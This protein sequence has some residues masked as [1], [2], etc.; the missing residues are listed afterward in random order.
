M[1]KR[2]FIKTFGAI[3]LIPFSQNIRYDSL[4]KIEHLLNTE[5]LSDD[6]FWK[7]VRSQ[8]DLHQDFINLESGYYNIIPKPTLKKQI[9]HI[10]RVNLEG[11]FYMRKSRFKDKSTITSELANFVGCNGKN[12][13]ITR[14]TTESLDLIISGFPWKSGDEAIYAYQD[15]GAMQDMFEQIGKRHG[16]VLKKVSVP[17]H[18]KNDMELISL[19]ESQITSKTRLIMISHMVNIT[20][21]IL[22]V[23]K[24]CDMAHSYGVE[25]LVDGAHC[26]GHFNFKI[27]N[28]NCDYYGSSLHKWLATPLG[29]GLLYVNNKHIP[30]IW[31]LIAD[32]EKDPN[33]I[34]RLSHTGTHPV[35]TDLTIID[36]IEYLNS[37]GIKK[38][39]SRLRFLKTYW[40]NA[41]KN[42]SNIVINTP[43][44][45]QR[46]CGI[47]N[48]GLKNMKPE[49]L[50][51]RLY[52]EFGIFT[53][54]IDYANVKGCR[55]TPNIFTNEN[56]L[57]TFIDAMK[58][59][60]RS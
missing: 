53:V 54:A 48:V 15:Y 58:S 32:H 7:L 22:P 43:F 49:T 2:D 46:S 29:A 24:I 60:A 42:E 16:V 17:N 14:N 18:P 6:D 57:D 47:G 30:K 50:A 27:D 55:I 11:S 23:K 21:Q 31:P 41:L 8:Y 38:K 4:N 56:E 3:G 28:L 33:K 36:A 37:I 51:N 35:S 20:G 40:Q 19:Y 44:D 39:E 10:K 59:L 12:L 34:Q 26:V 52:K 5:N 9:E 25:V 1:K 45:P 13:V